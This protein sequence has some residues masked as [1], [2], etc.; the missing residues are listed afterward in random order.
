MM[1]VRDTVIGAPPY[2]NW[3][4]VGVLRLHRAGS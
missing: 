1:A 3:T 4:A 2:P